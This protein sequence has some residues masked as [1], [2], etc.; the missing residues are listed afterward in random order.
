M[1]KILIYRDEGVAQSSFQNLF[2]AL[3]RYLS[4]FCTIQPVN[5]DHFISQEWEKT[6]RLLVFPGGRDLPYHLKLQGSANRR[7]R[8]Y[9][10]EG[11]R[12]FGVCA[13]GYYGSAY[14]EFEKGGPFE[15]IGPRELAFFPGK[16]VGPA[17]QGPF[18]YH[19]EIGARAAQIRWKWGLCPVY[20]HGG[21]LFEGAEKYS[22]IQILARYSDLPK[23]PAAAVYCPYGRGAALLIGVHPEYSMYKTLL[24][25]L[26]NKI[27]T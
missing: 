24:K 12:Y 20:F 7:I 16:A 19:S 18:S 17:Y 26:I 13:G 10:N 2:E 3:S 6:T 22:S 21:C 15:I 8:N 9:V 1:S 4:A 11:G 5:H 23:E 14:V 25:Y 27:L